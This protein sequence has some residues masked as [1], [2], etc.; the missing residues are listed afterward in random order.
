MLGEVF[1]THPPR[2]DLILLGIGEDG[3][4]ASLFPGSL[5]LQEQHRLVVANRA[6][7]PS[8]LSPDPSGGGLQI[9]RITF[10]LPLINAAKVVVFLVTEE[11]KAA[12]LRIVLEP[13]PGESTLPAAMVLPTDGTVHWFLSVEASALLKRTGAWTP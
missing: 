7:H 13:T 10:T 3:H 2:F 11:S 6:P 9:P 12:V 5:G 8:G 1:E 4:T